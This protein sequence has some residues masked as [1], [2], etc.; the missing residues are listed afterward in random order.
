M[1]RQALLAPLVEEIIA[2]AKSQQ[3]DLS[4]RGSARR[5]LDKAREQ[6]PLADAA[7]SSAQIHALLDKGELEQAVTLAVQLAEAFPGEESA[8]VACSV[9]ETARQAKQV[10]V[11]VLCFTSAVLSSPPCDRACWQLCNLSVERRD[12]TLAP[13]WL[14]Y[15]ARFLGSQGA[16]ADAISVYRQLLNLAPRRSDV[17]E[18]L[19]ISSLT[20][21]LPD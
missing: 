10:E 11:A 2:T 15:I 16:D 9:G 19:R 8:A 7:D 17:R 3:G 20:G 12:A 14:E 1:A 5:A 18:L 21:T 4:K 13:V 6:L